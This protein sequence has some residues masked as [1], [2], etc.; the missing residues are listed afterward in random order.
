[1][2]NL[3]KWTVWFKFKSLQNIAYEIER[4]GKIF[5][6]IDGIERCIWDLCNFGVFIIGFIY[7]IFL[8]LNK[9]ILD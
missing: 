5:L 9:I 4:F 8:D 1:M 2:Y 3:N 7:A 6:E